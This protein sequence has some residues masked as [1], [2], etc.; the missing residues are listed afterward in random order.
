MIMVD[1]DTDPT[2]IG[3]KV[4]DPVW[5]RAT[6]FLDQEVMDPDFFRVALGAI[7]APVVAEI[8]DQ[9]LFLGVDGDHRLL[10]GQSGGHLGIDVA[11]LCIPVGVAVALRGLAVALQTVTASL[12]KWATRVRL[13]S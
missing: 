11:E 10:F 1:A 2:R 6:Q 3:R 13:T 12:S 8:P 7:F 9:F 5:H 4:V